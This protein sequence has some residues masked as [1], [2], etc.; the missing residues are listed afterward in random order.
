MDPA[1]EREL[2]REVV[3]AASTSGCTSSGVYTGST[4]R[5]ETEVKSLSLRVGSPDAAARQAATSARRRA[6][7][8]SCSA[9]RRALSASR[10]V[11]HVVICARPV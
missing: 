5:P 4:E 8:R 1:G 3:V 6:S 10:S 7:S 2:A 11:L 9:R